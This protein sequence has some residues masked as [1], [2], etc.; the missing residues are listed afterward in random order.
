MQ[1]FPSH[2]HI[3]IS[4]LPDIKFSYPEINHVL[5]KISR[6]SSHVYIILDMKHVFHSINLT[7]E[8]KQNNSCCASPGSPTNQFNRLSQGLHVSPAHFMSFM[9]DLLHKLPS[10]IHEYIDCIMDDVII[11]TPDIKTHKKVLRCFMHMLKKYGMLLTINKIHNFRSKVKY[12][13]LLLSGKD[14]FPTITPISNR[15]KVIATLPIPLTMRGI[16]SFIRGVIYLSQF[17]P[18]LSELIKPMNDILKLCN[19]DNRCDKIPPLGDFTKGKGKG[20]IH[21]PDIQKY[22]LLLHSANFQMIKDLIVHAPVLHLPARSGQFYLECDSSAKHVG[23]VLY[24]IQNGTKSIVAYYSATMP[25]AA[26]RYLSSELEL[27]GLKKSLL[28]FQYL[29]KYS[30]FTLLI[31]HSTLKRIY[32]SWNPPKTVRI[33][34]FLVKIS[35]FSF[36]Y[37]HISGKHMFVSDFL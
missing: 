3:V 17:L 1:N 15:I 5:H 21:S 28:L 11:F 30:T 35:D 20:K 2:P 29:L 25:D 6:H 34:K 16:K 26:S 14:N 36:D 9:N 37:Q 23:S 22:W 19:K 33:Q 32:C 7:E 18:K 8:S 12:M 24:Q 13:A 4:H 31:D 10:D 27:C